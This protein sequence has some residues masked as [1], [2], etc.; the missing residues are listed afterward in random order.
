MAKQLNHKCIVCGQPYHSCDTCEKIKSYSPWR[1][2]TDTFKHYQIYVTIKSFDSN[3]ISQEEAIQELKDLG[4]TKSL[5]KDWPEGT[6]KKL[7]AIFKVA[8][9]IVEE[10][11]SMDKYSDMIAEPLLEENELIDEIE[12]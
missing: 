3:I 10:D 6:Q 1:T 2:V 8:S 11:F 12:D 9:P 7:D 4:V 5:Y